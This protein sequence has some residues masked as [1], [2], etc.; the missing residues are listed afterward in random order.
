MP[1]ITHRFPIK[2][3]MKEVFDAVSTPNGPDAWWTKS[4]AGTPAIGEEY[5]LFFGPGYDWS[6][7][8]TKCAAGEFE[9]TIEDAMDD[10]AGTRVGFVLTENAGMTQVEFNHSGWSEA[11]EH[12]R[13]SSFCWAMYLRLLRR[14]LE[15]GEIVEYEA[16]LDA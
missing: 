8:A 4:S 14:Y 1:S 2:A 10:W 11:G 5:R 6:A 16:R 3:P 13:T 9:L 12:F 15:F 7:R